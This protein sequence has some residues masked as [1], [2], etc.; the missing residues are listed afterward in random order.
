MASPRESCYNKVEREFARVVFVLDPGGILE[1]P[2]AITK[3]LLPGKRINLLRRPRLI[4]FLHEHIERKLL[5]ISA[6]AGYGKTS[7]LIDFARDTTLPVCWYSLDASDADP[8]TFLEYLLAS[9]HRRFPD[10]GARTQNLLADPATLRDVDV[11]IGTLVTEIYE[12]IP[13]YFI[14]ILDD[15]HAVEESDAIN[16]IVDTFLRLLPE[17]AHLILSSRTL[18]SKLTLTRLTAQAE[19]AGLGV[20]DLRFTAE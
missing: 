6:S 9:L 16:H 19:I 13:G 15:Y 2:R 14:L 4:N 8:K 11:V 20:N 10:F 12:T 5:L 18:P 3:I 1:S 17:N 7:L